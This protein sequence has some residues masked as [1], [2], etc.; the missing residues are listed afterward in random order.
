[1]TTE[2]RGRAATP[3]VSIARL[4]RADGAEFVAAANASKKLH[5][6]WVSPP[7]TPAAY[8]A[9]H[10]RMAAPVH[11]VFAIRRRDSDA[12]AGCAEVTNVVRGG[13]LSA[14]LGYYAFAGHERQG[15]MQEGIALVARHAFD[16]LGLHRLEANVQPGNAASL[17]LVRACGFKKE[18]YSPKYLKIHGRWRDHERWALLAE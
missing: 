1:M 16:R 6:T 17:A 14:Y 15:L 9:W 2:R 12:L 11:Y 3:R 13:F 7:L 4:R 5:A 18:G 8:R 10:R